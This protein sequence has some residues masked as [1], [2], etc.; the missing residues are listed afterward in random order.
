MLPNSKC[1]SQSYP[2]GWNSSSNKT[3]HDTSVCVL[4]HSE[5]TVAQD[6][7]SSNWAP[8][9]W[10]ETITDVQVSEWQTDHE[11]HVRCHSQEQSWCHPVC[12]MW[13]SNLDSSWRTPGTCEDQAI[14]E[15][16][17]LFPKDRSTCKEHDIETFIACKANSTDGHPKRLQISAFPPPHGRLCMLIFVGHFLLEST[18]SWLLIPTPYTRGQHSGINKL[19]K[20]PTMHGMILR[21]DN[22]PPFS[23][24]EIKRYMKEKFINHKNITSLWLQSNSETEGFMK[25]LTKAICSARLRRENSG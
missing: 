18:C 20:I 10:Q 5:L 13:K 23:S 24:Y 17:I 12:A 16:E 22:G 7:R 21:S 15:K 6:K 14:A 25:P 2:A 1:S 8:G 4:A 3:R 19:D 9:G 11:C